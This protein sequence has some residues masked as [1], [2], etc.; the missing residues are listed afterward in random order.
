MKR[1]VLFPI[2]IL[3][4]ASHVL[5]G[6]NVT[7]PSPGT[8]TTS[9][10]NPQPDDYEDPPKCESCGE[11]VEP[12]ADSSGKKVCPE[13]SQEVKAAKSIHYTVGLGTTTYI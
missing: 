4:A 9:D 12:T 3:A 6:Q 13:G 5:V 1:L 11:E 2:L 8:Q 10:N 7:P